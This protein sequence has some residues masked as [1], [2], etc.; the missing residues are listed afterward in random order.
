MS[1]RYWISALRS[2]AKHAPD[3][4]FLKEWLS[5]GLR[6]DARPRASPVYL[7]DWLPGAD[8]VT[9][10]LGRV[11]FKVSNQDPFKRFVLAA[12][13]QLRK[14]KRI[15]EIGT[16]DGATTLLLARNAPDAEI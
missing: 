10:D 1:A 13:C 9:V 14:P 16:F 4:T 5:A 8:Q 15:F 11:R 2:L 12:W 6:E 3:R 7:H